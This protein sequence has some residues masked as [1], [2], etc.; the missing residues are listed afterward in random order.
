MKAASR[1]L[2]C[3][4]LLALV[5]AAC[6]GGSDTPRVQESPTSVIEDVPVEADPTNTP[7]EPTTAVAP[8]EVPSLSP[9]EQITA[10]IAEY[11]ANPV[12]AGVEGW[13]H[14]DAQFVANRI[15]LEVCIW[16]GESVFENLHIVEY[17]VEPTE[18]GATA[19]RLFDNSITGTCESDA[20][21]DSLFTTMREFDNFWSPVLA[22]PTSFD[23]TTAAK[24]NT[25][26]LVSVATGQVQEWVADGL[27]WRQQA[28]DG[29]LPESAVADLLWRRFE[30]AKGI[31]NLEV[32]TCRPIAPDFGLYRGDTIV[33]DFKDESDPGPHSILLYTIER[34][35]GQ[36][37]VDNV[38]ASA[39]ADCTGFG[40]G[41]LDAVNEW[42]PEPI[43]WGVLFDA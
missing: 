3:F 16:T 34:H 24:Y 36:W 4:V 13:E 9:D 20:L 7:V 38:D 22:D 19:S 18:N 35:D 1:F 39:W 29:L 11:D 17:A 2:Y 5:A 27:S 42:R 6:A 21:V 23:P 41:W 31:E 8:T 26:D 15:R 25:R 14:V 12:P 33:D 37:L 32:V 43:E 30:N 10:A 40:D 28:Y